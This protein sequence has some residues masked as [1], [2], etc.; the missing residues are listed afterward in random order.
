MVVRWVPP[1]GL[2]PPFP[3]PL[4]S[5]K[6]LLINHDSIAYA[7]EVSSLPVATSYSLGPE[8][9]ETSV[10][11]DFLIQR[12]RRMP[13]LTI[14]MLE[15]LGSGRTRSW[16]CGIRRWRR[17]QI[18]ISVQAKQIHA[19]TRRLRSTSGISSENIKNGN[20]GESKPC[21]EASAFRFLNKL[22]RACHAPPT[23]TKHFVLGPSQPRA[24]ARP[25]TLPLQA[26]LLHQRHNFPSIPH[27][28]S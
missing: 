6:L 12:I 28:P 17:W 27:H 5:P 7:F 10:D 18:T 16:G 20:Q 1:S 4:S 15:E 21:S 13:D 14:R 9:M 3:I 25:A 8:L 11:L 2:S 22:A 26:S 24:P 19:C 23:L